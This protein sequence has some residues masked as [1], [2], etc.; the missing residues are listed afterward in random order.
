MVSCLI[1]EHKG[2]RTL[3]E[4]IR[5]GSEGPNVSERVEMAFYLHSPYPS[6]CLLMT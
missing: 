1:V 2:N 5:S 3:E 6:F 4:E